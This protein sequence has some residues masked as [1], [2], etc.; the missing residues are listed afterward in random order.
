MA[1]IGR[2]FPQSTRLRRPTMSMY[3]VVANDV[4]TLS[5]SE[6]L[7]SNL[8]TV[9]QAS[10]ETDVTGWGVPGSGG[11]CTIQPAGL[12]KLNLNQA[13]VNVDTT[14]WVVNANCT[15][16]R[17]LT[18]FA[19][20][21]SSLAMT[22]VT[23]GADMLAET[24][25]SST[26]PV[27]VGQT[28][29]ALA[30]FK[31]ATTVRNC[32]SILS[33]FKADFS[34]L[35]SN[36]AAFVANTTS[37]WTQVAVTAVAPA[38]AAYCKVAVRVMV[39]ATSEVHYV[40]KVGLFDG[41]VST[42]VLPGPALDGIMSMALTATAATTMR[43]TT[44]IPSG[45]RTPVTPG[46]TYKFTCWSRAATTPRNMHAQIHWFNAG[47]Y[48]SSGAGQTQQMNSTSG[49]T[50]HTQTAVCP[51][52][53][54]TAA[55]EIG[56]SDV[57][58]I[59]EVHYGDSF[60]LS[61][62]EEVVALVTTV[63]AP[64]AS[65]GEVSAPLMAF[66]TTDAP[67]LALDETPVN[68]LTPNQGGF[69]TDA[70]FWVGDPNTTIARTTS[71]FRTGPAALQL[72]AVAVQA[73]NTAT[74]GGTSGIPGIIPGQVYLMSA[75]SK[76]ATVP[77]GIQIQVAWFNGAGGAIGVGS[78]LS[79]GP[80]PI[81]NTSTW[82]Q[83][84]HSAIAPP[85]AAYMK[86]VFKINDINTAAG[87]VHYLDD[88][89]VSLVPVQ[90]SVGTGDA[91]TLSTADVSSSMAVVVATT[92]VPAMTMWENPLPLSVDQMTIE[93]SATGWSGNSS[94]TTVSRTT[95]ISY[96]GAASLVL[97]SLAAGTMFAKA[98]PSGSVA[99]L[100]GQVWTLTAWFRA[101]T[102]PRNCELDIIWRDSGGSIIGQQFSTPTM[103][104]PSGWTFVTVTG[105]APA[106][107]AFVNPM[108][109]VD[110]TGAANE[111]H[112]VDNILL[113]KPNN[114]VTTLA[115]VDAPTVWLDE[116]TE[117]LTT[118][119]GSIETDASFWVASGGSPT[120]ARST[121][122]SL[123]GV[124]S[125]KITATANGSFFA[126]SPI[127][128]SAIPVP[129]GRVTITGY[130]MWAAGATPRPCRF[131]VGWYD[132]AGSFVSGGGSSGWVAPTTTGWTKN[133][134]VLQ[135]PPAGA[136]Y[137]NI[138]LETDATALTGDAVYWDRISVMWPAQVAASVTRTDT[139]TML[140]TEG[141]PLLTATQ[142]SFETGTTGWEVLVNSSIG[143]STA[144][145]VDGAQSMMVT[146]TAT[147]ANMTAR[148]LYGFSIPVAP[149]TLITC[150]AWFRAATTGRSCR[151]FVNWID[152]AS[153]FL[154]STS[155]G[156]TADVTGS[157]TQQVASGTAPQPVSGTLVYAIVYVEFS[158][159]AAG[160]VHYV[161]A[162]SLTTGSVVAA[163]VSTADVLRAVT[164]EGLATNLLTTNQSGLETDLTGWATET[165]ATI[166]RSTS[167][168]LDGIASLQVTV[169]ATGNAVV[170]I[171]L[172]NAIPVTPGVAYIQEGWFKKG[173][174]AY[175]GRPGAQ[176]NWL[177]AGGGYISSTSSG[178]VTTTDTGWTRSQ[179]VGIAPPTA[180]WATPGMVIQN[181]PGV[182]EVHYGDRFSAGLFTETISTVL[183]TT[184]VPTLSS[185]EGTSDVSGMVTTSDTTLLDITEWFS[186]NLY[187]ANASSF[188][189]SPWGGGSN[190]TLTRVNAGTAMEGTFV[191]AMTNTAGGSMW[192]TG[193]Q[194]TGVIP[195]QAYT[196]TAWF[197]AA[198]VGRNPVYTVLT[199][200]DSAG[201]FLANS[202]G[203]GQDK[204]TGWSKV[205]MTATAP[206]LAARV[207]VQL[208]IQ[209]PAAPAGEV[210]WI[211]NVSLVMA[212]VAATVLTTDI[213][214]L[215]ATEGRA[216]AGT[217]TTTDLMFVGLEEG[218][219][220]LTANQQSI[221]IDASNW[222]AESNC[223]PFR[224]TTQSL[225]G[226]FSLGLTVNAATTQVRAICPSSG[227]IDVPCLPGQ[228]VTVSAW[229][230]SAAVSRIF[231]VE[232]RFGKTDSS[233]VS[234]VPSAGVATTT[235]GWVK[236]SITVTAP[237]GTERVRMK[238]EF[239]NPAGGGE[240]HYVD[241]ASIT[242]GNPIISTLGVSDAPIMSYAEAVQLL[243]QLVGFDTLAMVG[244]D[245]RTLTWH[246]LGRPGSMVEGEPGE[247]HR[248]W[249]RMMTEEPAG[250]MS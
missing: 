24:V 246:V 177:T 32:R 239:D 189:T 200:L 28:Y 160:E 249:G 218:Q 143:T 13:T 100:P 226:S 71:V 77:R 149:G 117:Q 6:G 89:S 187:N 62:V 49:W 25:P 192:V 18:Q 111:V 141:A 206:A 104:S 115:A 105:T 148:T 244:I 150:S 33:W 15:L 34:W 56:S 176:I 14:G 90:V 123:D 180:A 208:N 167:E 59:G 44:E 161:D 74:L 68:L 121:A 211:D 170:R 156:F 72:T 103:N 135:P 47:G 108:V 165:N 229:A 66:S 178:I 81:N 242:I 152:G 26:V 144:Q 131:S 225:D 92:D 185:T 110:S 175:V 48:V 10:V 215:S 188:E 67:A 130:T 157:W 197:R 52:G 60:Y 248:V 129:P 82:T 154:G 195:G 22:C 198:T 63:D 193:P 171:P 196:A 93:T 35:A 151:V 250:T 237:A 95:A 164:T 58:A 113:L 217:L 125:L 169:T 107:T 31:A 97:T 120:V 163:S 12:N 222:I 190:C 17:D 194:L 159:P 76:A 101:A 132:N 53:I 109:Q 41:T 39:P 9:N 65:Y 5:S 184:D 201:G 87:E 234:S 55:V 98:N 205:A 23:G 140:A 231:H 138:N 21:I 134:V 54:T 79:Y 42:W 212:L 155:A 214:T 146:A 133:Q 106:L 86:V 219:Q 128:L 61:V 203:T 216:I 210:H 241:A 238:V 88:V 228:A 69:D 7:G 114:V 139:P 1:Q 207:Q 37:G 247:M 136:A 223:V 94:N 172:A 3:N 233:F 204:T 91:P 119:Q 64:T 145:A 85:T 173:N 38:L 186:A 102:V 182:G 220:Q 57:V 142:Q 43:A 122:A 8:L 96:E 236:Q 227:G 16:A 40:D 11:N 99:A 179:S 221:E 78:I 202:V 83:V 118:N 2:T 183:S 191:M 224:S 230:K 84:Q 4:P 174:A 126:R 181:T 19:D 27:V 70:S 116:G 137:V 30:S 232:I 46:R 199:W 75:W 127:G 235:T 20:G 213:P 80:T 51:P 147:A 243:K 166:A 240:I 209:D 36:E 158:N 124:A 29:T 112:Y 50:Q 73:M 245:A 153:N 162:V 168:A 45:N